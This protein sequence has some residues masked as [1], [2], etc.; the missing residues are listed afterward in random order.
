MFRKAPVIYVYLAF[1]V[2]WYSTRASYHIV[3]YWD[4]KI[5]YNFDF[6][7]K[8]KCLLRSKQPSFLYSS[9]T[10]YIMLISY[11]CTDAIWLVLQEMLAGAANVS[12]YCQTPTRLI[13]F[14]AGSFCI[15]IRRNSS[16]HNNHEDEV[17]TNWY[18]LKHFH[19]CDSNAAT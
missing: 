5:G 17:R 14:H 7:W 6:T 2:I 1:S 12:Q 16:V 19:W 3:D 8:M 15:F 11:W 13:F 9:P 4:I 18:S 10:A